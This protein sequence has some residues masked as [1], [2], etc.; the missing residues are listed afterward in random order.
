MISCVN[1]INEFSIGCSFSLLLLP[2]FINS[3]PSCCDKPYCS[4]DTVEPHGASGAGARS[5]TTDTLS[6]SETSLIAFSTS[7]CFHDSCSFCCACPRLCLARATVTKRGS[8]SL[9]GG[10]A[11]NKCLTSET[12]IRTSDDLTVECPASL[13]SSE[14]TSSSREEGRE[15]AGAFPVFPLG[16]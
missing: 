9:G 10:Q 15:V 13:L 16:C 2:L 8:L 14:G 11:R 7:I 4:G 3:S 1:E 6:F 5:W 12:V